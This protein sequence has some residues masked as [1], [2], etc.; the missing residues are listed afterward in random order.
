MGGPRSL[1]VQEYCI[2]VVGEW[3]QLLEPRGGPPSDLFSLGNVYG[4]RLTLEGEWLRLRV[5]FRFVDHAFL[6][7]WC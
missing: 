6:N 1:E 5:G 4:E 3:T 2:F 7:V